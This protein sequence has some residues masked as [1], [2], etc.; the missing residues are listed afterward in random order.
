LEWLGW[1]RG[2]CAGAISGSLS[3]EIGKEIG[4]FSPLE[5]FEHRFPIFDNLWNHFICC[6]KE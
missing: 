4:L 3:I 1:G 6:L 2:Q 5:S